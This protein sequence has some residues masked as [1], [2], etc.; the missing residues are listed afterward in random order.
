[1]GYG[2]DDFVP[3]DNRL[4]CNNNLVEYL[5]SFKI[6]DYLDF[7]WSKRYTAIQ[8][9]PISMEHS[10]ISDM[11]DKGVISENFDFSKCI[12]WDCDYGL[13]NLFLVIP[14]NMINRWKRTDDLLDAY[15]EEQRWHPSACQPRYHEIVSGIY[16]HIAK[17][18]SKYSGAILDQSSCLCIFRNLNSSEQLDVHPKEALEELAYETIEDFKDEVTP[19]T[20][21]SIRYL[22]EFLKLFHDISVIDEFRSFYYVYW[23]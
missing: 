23:R 16:P 8:K 10:R 1:M 20:P 19:Y 2:L 15:D 18:Q 22:C 5:M 17:F 12:E 11:L 3:N 9:F 6:Q 14:V 21:E 7:L 13:K 4:V